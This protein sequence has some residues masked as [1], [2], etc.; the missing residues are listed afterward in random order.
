M[1]LCNIIKKKSKWNKDSRL[2][3]SITKSQPSRFW[4]MKPLLDSNNFIT[5]TSCLFIYFPFHHPHFHP[6]P[7]FFLFF[8]Y[9]ASSFFSFFNLPCVAST[10]TQPHPTWIYIL[11]ISFFCFSFFNFINLKVNNSLKIILKSILKII[12]F[13][14]GR[15]FDLNSRTIFVLFS[16]VMKQS[17]INELL[18]IYIFANSK[19][20][21]N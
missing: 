5:S 13:W 17:V 3:T 9:S 14:K 4:N 16:N 2:I 10:P 20:L 18:Y 7:P 8:I 11:E 19:T 21:V 12:W 15:M 6:P 1:C